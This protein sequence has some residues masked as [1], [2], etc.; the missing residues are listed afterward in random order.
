M[1]VNNWTYTLLFILTLFFF[2]FT[3][4]WAY[5]MQVLKRNDLSIF[6]RGLFSYV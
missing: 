6:V 5:F 1:E 2:A 4:D 3:V